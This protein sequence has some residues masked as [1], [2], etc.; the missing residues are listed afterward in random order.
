MTKSPWAKE[1]TLAMAEGGAMRPSLG[2][3]GGGRGGRGGGGMGGGGGDMG[4]GGGGGIGGGGGDLGGGGG[5]GG[6]GAGGGGGGMPQVPQLPK[7]SVRWESAS[8]YRDAMKKL[9]AEGATQA[10]IEGFYVITVTGLKIGMGRGG[11]SAS[12]EQLARARERL[13]EVTKL[14]RKGKDPIGAAKVE[15][16]PS[17]DGTT[18]RFYFPRSEPINVEDKEVVFETRMGPMEL[19]TK[20]PLKDM[21]IDGKLAL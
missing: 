15:G 4:G 7:A 5:G 11:N 6:M 14:T 2:G 12:V 9:N 18:L 17:T 8:A 19:K 3:G 16:T 10:D 21:V 20:F 1:T 13:K